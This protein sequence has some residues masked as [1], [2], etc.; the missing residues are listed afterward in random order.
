VG[1]KESSWSPDNWMNLSL[2]WICAY[3]PV[4]C[5]DCIFSS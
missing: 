5:M 4:T 1:I 2:K 3:F